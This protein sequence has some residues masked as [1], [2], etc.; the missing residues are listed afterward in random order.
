MTAMPTSLP[1]GDVW[2]ELD[3]GQLITLAPSGY[4]QGRRLARITRIL[5][6]A[7]D[8]GLGEACAETTV[9]L[10]RNPDRVVAP[11]AAFILT[12]SLPARRSPEGCLETIPELV[13]EIRGKNDTNPEIVAVCEEYF[14]AAVQVWVIDPPTRTVAALHSD[15]SAQIFRDTDT[16]T[17]GLLP[18][19]TA[20]VASLFAGT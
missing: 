11:D 13:V 7:K 19:F 12:A 6:N 16:L 2:Y 1:S 18:G 17:C 14:R 9:I 3:D 20:P 8:A 5:L 4:D 10:R 15:G